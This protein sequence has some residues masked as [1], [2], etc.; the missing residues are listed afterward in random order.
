[1]PEALDATGRETIP[2]NSPRFVEKRAVIVG[3]PHRLHVVAA[4]FMLTDATVLLKRKIG[5]ERSYFRQRDERNRGV[6]LRVDCAQQEEVTLFHRRPRITA[7]LKIA[8]GGSN[9]VA[10]WTEK[11][12]CSENENPGL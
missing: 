12:E 2:T 8:E 7:S 6:E 11:K 10:P 9:S 3:I 4:D 5:A 1:V